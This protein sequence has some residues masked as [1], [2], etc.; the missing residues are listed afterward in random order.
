MYLILWLIIHVCYAGGK[1]IGSRKG[2]GV[3]F[4]TRAAEPLTKARQLREAH[5]WSI[6]AV[7]PASVGRNVGRGSLRP[8]GRQAREVEGEAQ[9]MGLSFSLSE[10]LV[11]EPGHI[12]CQQLKTAGRPED[13]CPHR[14]GGREL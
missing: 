6:Y 4:F 13:R 5:G 7:S 2:V 12:S 1:S 3:G 14:S 11:E 8:M 9:V 10:I